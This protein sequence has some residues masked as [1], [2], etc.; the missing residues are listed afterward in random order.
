MP[1]VPP[2][3]VPGFLPP[4]MLPMG[5]GRTTMMEPPPETKTIIDKTAEF[6]A[7]LG[8]SFEKRI[9]ENEAH[10]PKFS[11]LHIPDPFHRYYRHKI[12]EFKKAHAKERGE[13]LP[14][15]P[16]AKPS[17]LEEGTIGTLLVK[18]QREVGIHSLEPEPNVFLLDVPKIHSMDLDII[19]LTAQFVARNGPQ[20][21]AGLMNREAKNAQFEFLKHT[22]PLN[23]YFS[24]LVE[25]Y[26]RCLL[27]SR[28]IVHR[29]RTKY[30]RP[31]D[32]LSTA[33]ERVRWQQQED[34]KRRK[35]EEDAEK[36]RHA[37]AS[38]D[39]HDFVV[40]EKIDFYDDEDSL[41]APKTAAQLENPVMEEEPKVE[42]IA[43]ETAGPQEN[44]NQDDDDMDMEIEG[45]QEAEPEEPLEPL[46]EVV[47][48]DSVP[49]EMKI[50][51]NYQRGAAKRAAT[52]SVQLCPKCGQEIPINEFA[53]HMR[54]E[55]MDPK[56]REQQDRA[57]ANRA[58]DAYAPNDAIANNLSSF[59]SRR[60]DIF[61]SNIDASGHPRPSGEESMAKRAKFERM[62]EDAY[63][64][65]FAGRCQIQIID[66]IG[67]QSFTYDFN[68]REA[69]GAVKAKL[70]DATEVRPGRQQLAT[71]DGEILEDDRSLAYYN[72]R[73][74]QQ[75]ILS[76]KQ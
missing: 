62:P 7:R 71:T 75:I 3:G 29:L 16:E 34:S 41:P 51:R 20:F 4:G 47:E 38:I 44:N 42:G 73:S 43:G 9:Y 28:D 32:V 72:I 70:Q 68:I 56:W 2:F 58:G 52:L 15:A 55:L 40:V 64:I 65:S 36:E 33:I 30:S 12:D 74:R 57:K 45:E 69:I 76:L 10:N 24:A 31:R 35:E 50:K 66:Q 26:S 14:Q 23:P 49:A 59:A 61:G 5:V 8:D 18:A 27:P 13:A 60:A 1:A 63:A 54:I 25:T 17:P 46:E 21:H 11:F 53:E 6:V 48:D 22:H 39:W 37:M 19:K 67:G